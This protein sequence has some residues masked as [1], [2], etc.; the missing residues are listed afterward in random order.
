MK[1]FK[2]KNKLLLGFGII[3]SFTFIITLIS[4]LSMMRL[5]D[6]TDI[7]TKKNNRQYRVCLGN[8]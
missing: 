7:L 6:Q 8:A 1:D 3:I 5:K 2:V 4:V